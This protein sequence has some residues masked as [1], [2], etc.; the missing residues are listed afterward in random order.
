MLYLCGM[1]IRELDNRE[2]EIVPLLSVGRCRQLERLKLEKDRK[3]CMAAG[4]LEQ[5][6]IHRFAGSWLSGE[7]LKDE[8]GKPF[9]SEAPQLHYNLSHA[10]DY[11]VA[12]FS[13]EP[14][15]IDIADQRPYK[16]S[17]LRRILT[18]YE[19]AWL[20][21]QPGQQQAF[22]RLW[23]AKESY[24]KWLGCGLRMDLR[25]VEVHLGNFP[26]AQEACLREWTDL[27]GYSI[28]VCGGNADKL[29]QAKE[30]HWIKW[31]EVIGM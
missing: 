5:Y 11:V 24:V 29:A 2:K 20:E 7:T 26:I 17:L 30:I 16:D 22:C 8:N 3:R 27:P 15:G 13:D 23:S 21:K 19:K 9:F 4:L 14:V 6:G 10:G 28:C 18:E 12:A 25:Q 1:D 31:L